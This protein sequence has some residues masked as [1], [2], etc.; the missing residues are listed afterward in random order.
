M[1]SLME[2][3]E[4]NSIVK[5]LQ[6]EQIE[7]VVGVVATTNNM[8]PFAFWSSDKWDGLLF[9]FLNSSMNRI[10]IIC[11]CDKESFGYLMAIVHKLRF[12][13]RLMFEFGAYH[14]QED[15]LPLKWST[16]M[17]T[18]ILSYI[19][20][21]LRLANIDGVKKAFENKCPPSILKIVLTIQK[22]ECKVYQ[23]EV[24]PKA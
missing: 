8:K 3:L 18:L 19:Y 15:E 16:I 17:G 11:V 20:L 1:S 6:P 10:A 9:A 21:F 22:E 13:A 23:V 12:V 14:L 2:V 24:S 5:F 7:G 4:S